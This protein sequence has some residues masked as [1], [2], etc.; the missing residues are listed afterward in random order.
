MEQEINNCGNILKGFFGFFSPELDYF[1]KMG[2]D[3]I[4][5][6]IKK[7]SRPYCLE[8]IFLITW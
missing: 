8:Y 6:Q 3:I 2:W 1:S 5:A 7:K 4:G